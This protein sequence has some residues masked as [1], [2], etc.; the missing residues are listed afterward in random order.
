MSSDFIWMLVGLFFGYI[1]GLNK[2]LNDIP[3]ALETC[4]VEKSRQEE[5]LL[6]YKNL[7]KKLVEEN[8][9]LRKKINE[10]NL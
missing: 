7:T 6:Y 3:K 4:T 1:I 5:D 10:K 9:E 2:K 8:Q